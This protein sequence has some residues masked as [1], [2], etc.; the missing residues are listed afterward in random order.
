[1]YFFIKLGRDVNHGERMD[2]IDFGGQRSRSQWTRTEIRYEPNTDLTV[3]YF[4]IKLGRDVNHGERMNSIDLGGLSSKGE[5][6]AGYN[7]QMWVARGCY[8]LCCYIYVCSILDSD[9]EKNCLILLTPRAH[10]AKFYGRLRLIRSVLRA[11]KFSLSKLIEIVLLWVYYTIPFGFSLFWHFWDIILQPLK[12]LPFWLRI[13]DEGSVPEMRI[14]SIL[15]IKSDLKWCIHLSRS[16]FLYF[17]Y[18]VSVT[19]GGPVSPRGHM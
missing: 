8:A 17:N 6:H 14:W 10:V 4:F 7:W 15:L 3:M 13:T 11:S 12:L 19:A 1:M 5:G 2:P 16:L 18:L 9:T